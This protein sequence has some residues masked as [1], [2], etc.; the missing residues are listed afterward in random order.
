MKKYSLII[1]IIFLFLISKFVIAVELTYPSLPGVSSPAPGSSLRDYLK[2]VYIFGL[3]ASGI[4]AFVV[5]V[6]AGIKYAASEIITSKEEA[7]KDIQNALFGLALL[8]SAYLILNTINPELVKLQIPSITPLPSGGLNCSRLG[9]SETSDKPCC[10]GLSANNVN[11]C[12]NSQEGS[13]C[14][15]T[16]DCNSPDL[17]CKNNVC[18]KLSSVEE[19]CVNNNDCK[20]P[21]RCEQGGMGLSYCH[22]P[23]GQKQINETCFIP[24]DCNTGLTCSSGVCT[25]NT[26]GQSCQNQQNCSTGQFCISS[27]CV[28][29]ADYGQ[30]CSDTVTNQDCKVPLLCLNN[31]NKCHNPPNQNKRIQNEPCAIDKDCKIQ[32]KC[33]NNICVLNTR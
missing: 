29:P 22:N 1:I 2:Y 3:G 10:S 21:L 26:L 7:R 25:Q 19:I 24:S 12:L 6:W 5:I 9:E 20:T 28:I 4:A 32:L 8:M 18:K 30:T 13:V 16:S 15:N 31:D 27:I 14:Q 23:L 33:S 11:T 17:Q